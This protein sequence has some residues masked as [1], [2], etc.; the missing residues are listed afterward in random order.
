M[1]VRNPASRLCLPLEDWPAPDRAAW[2]TLFTPRDVFADAAPARRWAAATRANHLHHYG[3]WLRWLATGVGL[4]P[5]AAPGARATPEAV[6]GFAKHLQD[7]VSPVSAAAGI[8]CLKVV[9]K[10][11]HPEM[12]WRWLMDL[13]NRLKGWAEP[14]R[15]RSDAIRPIEEIHWASA[16]ELDRL[17]ATP[18]VSV[19]DRVACRDMLI[20]LVL[21]AA[22]V[23][24]RNLASIE[25]GRHLI[26]AGGRSWLRFPEAE[27]KT[28]GRLSFALPHHVEPYL[29]FYL[30]QVRPIFGPA[31]DC[32][33]LWV[34]AGGLPVTPETVRFRILRATTRLFGAPINPHSFRACAATSFALRSPAMARQAAALLGHRRFATTE[35]HYVKANQLEASRGV[36]AVLAELRGDFRGDGEIGATEGGAVDH[37]FGNRLVS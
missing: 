25:I 7:R 9:L 33:R 17:A 19:S 21:S 36:N 5:D 11:M 26:Q 27:T 13:A 6:R 22:P 18:I 34:G 20:V 31:P 8:V 4:E 16:R 3:C 29:A 2:A 12:D 32:R 1:A 23:R 28:H 30:D 10:A 15:D 24:R 37:G 35:K 14:S